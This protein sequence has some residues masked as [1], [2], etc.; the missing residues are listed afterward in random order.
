VAQR[1][2]EVAEEMRRQAEDA[3]AAKSAFLATMSHEFR[4]P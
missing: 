3:N 1:A 2:T 4:T